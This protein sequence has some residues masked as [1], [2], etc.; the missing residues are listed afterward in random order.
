M[1][2]T[3][4]FLV[5]CPKC[6]SE[7][8]IITSEQV[9]S[10]LR[11]LYIQCKNWNC[12]KRLTATVETCEVSHSPNDC[13]LPELQPELLPPVSQVDLFPELKKWLGH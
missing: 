3:K 9:T 13:C 6:G 11:R 2:K 5:R 1:E 8:R 4:Q 10:N 12:G 7:T